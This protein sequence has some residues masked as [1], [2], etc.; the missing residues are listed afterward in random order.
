MS[1]IYNFSNKALKISQDTGFQGLV[2]FKS[3]CKIDQIAESKLEHFRQLGPVETWHYETGPMFL[4]PATDIWGEDGVTYF[5]QSELP[6][7][8]LDEAFF[9]ETSKFGAIF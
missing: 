8:A 5:Y 4:L 1:I 2:W 7:D 3:K 6:Y 9:E